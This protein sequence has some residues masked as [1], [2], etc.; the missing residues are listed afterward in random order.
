MRLI[1]QCGDLAENRAGFRHR[2][3]LS[4]SFDDR[5]SAAVE[6][7]QLSRFATFSEHVL[8][9]VVAHKP[10]RREPLSPSLSFAI[11]RHSERSCSIIRP[12]RE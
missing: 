6:N 7:Q 5:N 12:D 10:K 2:G 8:T 3:Y 1:Q 9:W 4:S 11:E